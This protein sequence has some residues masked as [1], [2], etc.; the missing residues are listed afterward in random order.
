M[1]TGMPELGSKI[2]LISKADIRYEGRLFTV[3]PQECTIALASVRSFGTEDRDT[4][5]PVAPQNQVYD[6]I[7]FRGSDIKDIRVVNNV[8]T[9]PNDPAIMQL[10]V[11]P[12]LGPQQFQAQ[13]FQHPVLGHMGPQMG[14]FG[15]GYSM[16]L[17]AGMAPG[18]SMSRDPR[19]P[20]SKPSELIAP[21]LVPPTDLSPAVEPPRPNDHDLIGGGSR[22]TTPASLGSRKSPTAD[23]GVQVSGAVK[24]D[25]KKLI[26]P[27][28]PP[29]QRG[30]GNMQRER[31]D[32]RGDQHQHQD[33][34]AKP[35]VNNQR[36]DGHQNQQYQQQPQQQRNHT[37]QQQ[38]PRQRQ[39]GWIPRGNVRQRGRS[40]G[41]YKPPQ[42]GP[43]PQANQ[44]GN[45]P[46]NTLK[47]DNDYD[48]E[49]ANTHFE[50]MIRNKLGKM[51]LDEG[52][53]EMNGDSDKKDDSGNETGAGEGE[54]E[55]EHEVY[56]DKSKSFFDNISCEAVERSKGRSQRTDWRTERKLNSETFGVAATRRGG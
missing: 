5:Y 4:S 35:Q 27:I 50:E 44:Q 25:D 30:P 34:Q 6:Y 40:R 1:S 32:S 22:S 43:A 36:K 2:S 15:A 55:E 53:P 51:K 19:M 46:K 38:Y 41:G 28:Q 9:L 18:M 12:S 21:S 14:Q 56:Y 3:D 37:Q 16:G 11:P 29:G 17:G 48:F 10:T 7:L 45:K 8:Q 20:T 24:K 49:E 26:R 13:A 54:Q 39:G 52:K 31:R 23:Q 42:T 33:Y 47:F